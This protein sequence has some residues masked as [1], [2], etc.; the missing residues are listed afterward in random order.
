MSA[1]SQGSAVRALLEEAIA[2]WEGG[3]A[4]LAESRCRDALAHDAEDVAALL[5]LGVVL[6]QR[7]PAAAYIALAAAAERDPRNA[8]AWFHLG[9]LHREQQRFAAA[10]AAYE[11]ATALAPSHPGLHNNLGLALEGA[12]HPERAAAAYRTALA[13]QPGQDVYKLTPDQVA[14]WRKAA[15]P[16]KAKWASQ[17]KDADTVFGELQTELK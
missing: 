5:L 10:V 2:A 4:A 11:S 14:V 9:N 6:R 12:G 7:D 1:R 15:E 8:D 3:D 13:A 17:V 16:L